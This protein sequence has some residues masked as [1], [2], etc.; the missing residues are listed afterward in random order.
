MVSLWSLR[1]SKS[2]QVS[3]TLLCI[4]ADLDNGVVWVESTCPFIS[5]S[6]CAFT[7][8]FG[9]VPRISS[10]NGTIVSFMF[11]SSFFFVCLFVLFVVV[12]VV[13]VVVVVVLRQGKITYLSVRFLLFSLYDLLGQQSPQFGKFS[14]LFLTINKSGRLVIWPGLGDP[15]VSQN[16][17][18]VCASHS[19]GQILDCAVTSCSYGQIVTR[20]YIT[21]CKQIISIK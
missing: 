7:D 6:F 18:K 15:F 5:K 16:P 1:D 14:F 10:T 3:W 20:N 21:V 2:R 13:I 4:L 8:P 19:A 9:I 17:R 12:V 11:H